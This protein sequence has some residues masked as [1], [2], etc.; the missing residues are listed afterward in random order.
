MAQRPLDENEPTARIGLRLRASDLAAADR[1]AGGPERGL[2]RSE[3]LRQA[4]AA[5]AAQEL[6]EAVAS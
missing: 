6:Q 3:V 4:L 2:T 5:L 1:I